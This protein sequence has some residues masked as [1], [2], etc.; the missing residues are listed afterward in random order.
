M[1]THPRTSPA[2]VGLAGVAVVLVLV[3]S[4]GAVPFDLLGADLLLAVAGYRVTQAV[5]DTSGLVAHYREQ[6]LLRAPLMVLGLAA[7]VALAALLGTPAVATHTAAD[8]V[9]GVV[10]AGNWWELLPSFPHGRSM[11]DAWGAALGIGPGLS[12]RTDPFAEYTGRIDPLG[13]LWL[14]GIL[15]QLTLVWPV[16]LTLLRRVPRTWLW[17]AVLLV[18]LGA[19]LVGP[20]RAAGGAGAAEL[21]LGTH[22]RAAEFLLG[23]AAA[24]FVASRGARDLPVTAGRLLLAGGSLTIGAAAALAAAAPQHWWSLGGPTLA[25]VGAA[26]LLVALGGAGVSL[27][28]RELGRGLPLELGHVAYP[29]LLLHLPVFWLVQQA[30]PAARPFALLGVGGAL[31]WLLALVLQ[32]GMVRRVARGRAGARIATGVVVAL[33]AVAVGGGFLSSTAAGSPGG[34]GQVVLVLGGADAG[35]LAAALRDN[36]RYRV[37]DGSRPGCGLL[38]DGLTVRPRAT[39]PACDTRP[40]QWAAVIAAVSP[41]AIVVDLAVDASPRSGAPGA[42][43]PGFR[44]AYRPLVSAAVDTWTA[45]NPSRPVLVADGPV[46]TRTGR[47]LDALI[48]ESVAARSA[49]VPLA[50]QST[51]CPTGVCDGRSND[52]NHRADVGR[53]VGNAVAVEL[54]STRTA[55]RTQERAYEEADVCG[56]GNDSAAGDASC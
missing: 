47:C 17:L 41:A 22:V 12:L 40:Q 28:A 38:P 5:L 55:E 52:Q 27:P 8:A 34:T 44:A 26:L 7:V 37:V 50:V 15:V 29:L 4:T 1:S 13:A 19:A 10:G 20:L 24:A 32:D 53:L 43:D 54:G 9:A 39:A 18:A 30:V 31:S 35:E 46:A 33:L 23:A 3:Q 48:T 56:V 21:G 6:F 16:L 25:A 14:I 51:M 2:I 49:L 36:G 45:G 42:C 11:L